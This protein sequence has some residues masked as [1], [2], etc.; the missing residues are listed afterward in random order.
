MKPTQ[1]NAMVVELYDLPVTDRKDD[2]YGR[3]VCHNSLTEN[4]LI[5]IAVDRGTELNPSTF[6]A[7]LDILKEIALGEILNGSAVTLGLTHIQPVVNGVFQGDDDHWDP[8]RHS[9]GLRIDP[10]GTLR[11][12]LRNVE[13]VLRGP[14]TTGPVINTVTDIKTGEVNNHLSPGGIISLK[15]QRMKITGDDPSV[16]VFL[17]NLLTGA[18]VPLAA[19]DQPPAATMQLITNRATELMLLLPPILPT[20][21]YLIKVST[22][23]SRSK[24]ALKN[25]V[26]FTFAPTLSVI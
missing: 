13:V 11:D 26:S 7:A 25:V 6:S 18:I 21:N 15:G 9:L 10:L 8:A 16:G 12:E 22:Q 4:D 24:K 1:K 19:T 23:Y 14:A 17:V 2:R 5:K 20:G 3:V